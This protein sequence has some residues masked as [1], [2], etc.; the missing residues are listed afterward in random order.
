MNNDTW[1]LWLRSGQLIAQG[2]KLQCVNVG[3]K[4][5]LVNHMNGSVVINHTAILKMPKPKNIW[6]VIKVDGKYMFQGTFSECMNI[7]DVLS[8]S[9]DNGS[10]LNSNTTMIKIEGQST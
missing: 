10:T 8:L 5:G 2:S 3:H 4:L 1:Q 9:P 7:V 6:W